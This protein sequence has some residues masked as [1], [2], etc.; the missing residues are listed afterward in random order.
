M[1][2]TTCFNISSGFYTKNYNEPQP[3]TAVR[4]AS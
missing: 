3:E 2:S 4:Q 1:T